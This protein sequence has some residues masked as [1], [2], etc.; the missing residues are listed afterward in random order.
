MIDASSNSSR[1]NA[2]GLFFQRAADRDLLREFLDGLGFPIY[3]PENPLV[4]APLSMQL[5]LL[6]VDEATARNRGRGMLALRWSAGVGILPM[7]VVLPSKADSE[8]WIQ[9]G[10]DDV[11]RQPI[12]KPDLRARIEVFLRLRRQSEQTR[13]LFEQALVGIYRITARGAVVAVNGPLA[14]LL[15]YESASDLLEFVRAGGR[16]RLEPTEDDLLARLGGAERVSGIE[17]I[18]VARNGEPVYVLE[19]VQTMRDGQGRIIGYDGSVADITEIRRRD[20]LLRYQLDL[21]SAVARNIVEGL[22][23]V[24]ESGTITYINRAA[25]RMLGWN[26]SEL[27]GRDVHESIHYKREDGSIRLRD[28]C[29]LIDALRDG[30]RVRDHETTFVRRDGSTF[31]VSCSVGSLR[32][33]SGRASGIFT[34]QDITARRARDEERDRLL[35]A[36]KLARTVAEQRL[37]ETVQLAGLYQELAPMVEPEDVMRAV[38]RAIRELTGAEGATF[39][40]RQ[41]DQVRYMEEDAIE[42]LWKGSSFDIDTC[43]SGQAILTGM[44]I[45]VS[46]ARVD[47]IVPR[48]AYDGTF[49]ESM[50]VVPF[51]PVD[52]TGSIGA[53]W[54]TRH[55][56]TEE[57]VR[58]MRSVASAAGLAYANAMSFQET[59]VARKHAEESSRLKDEFLA[60]ASHELRTPLNAIVGWAQLLKDGVENQDLLSNALGV[61]ERQAQSLTR[62]VNDL[63]DV[64]RIITGKLHLECSLLTVE[65]LIEGAVAAIRP[66]AAAKEIT[67]RTASAS[68][69]TFVVGDPARLQQALWNLLANAVKFTPRGGTVT[70]AVSTRRDR[71]VR[72]SVR[73]S[74]EGVSAEFLP[75]VFDRFRQA[76]ARMTR[77]HGGL[78]LGLA[79]VRH[80][81]ELHGGEVGARSDGEGC[82]AEFWIDLPSADHR[83]E[84]TQ[85][86]PPA[87]PPTALP[88]RDQLAG[89]RILVIDDDSDMREI[90][91]Q[92]LAS[93]GAT[94]RTAESVQTAVDLLRHELPD[95][96]LTDLGMPDNDGYDLLRQLRSSAG[97]HVPVAAVTAYARDVDRNRALEAGFDTFLAKPIDA[98]ELV[99]AVTELVQL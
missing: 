89:M 30:E 82:G 42:P 18:W 79:I 47:P 25:E 14:R 56:A 21:T 49:V 65:S 33:D 5:S 68:G 4:D 67:L 59:D 38:C 34:F 10:F 63:L 64:S 2:I 60:T 12:T 88:R 16:V 87:P 76:D 24:D 17:S 92:I 3:A 8:P 40:V 51:H 80:L 28:D 7:L 46:D 83:L 62:L 27:V 99:R 77:K 93:A 19:A 32:P 6:I 94:V 37:N 48:E 22:C 36:E 26:S 81:V 52:S 84:A 15:G 70:V 72:I 73:D 71:D 91:A 39:V 9:A 43:V 97:A 96:V 44:P 45:A 55:A 69:L 98:D 53:Y 57:D 61:I 58:V 1:N 95:V 41:D 78:G 13:E 11:L 29:R 85:A 66:A 50:L 23:I 86:T 35:A 75:F 31:P 54:A 90:L 20:D 74:G